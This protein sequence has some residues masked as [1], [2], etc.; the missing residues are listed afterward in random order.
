MRKILLLLLIISP[1]VLAGCVSQSERNDTLIKETKKCLEAGMKAEEL[2]TL[3][4]IAIDIQCVPN[5]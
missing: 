3:E 1:I 5:K 4:G 2:S